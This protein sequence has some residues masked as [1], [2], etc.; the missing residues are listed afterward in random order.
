MKSKEN[1]SDRLKAIMEYLGLCPTVFAKN[2]GISPTAVN[3][4]F[5]QGHIPRKTTIDKIINKY[6]IRREWLENGEGKMWEEDYF[7]ERFLKYGLGARTPKEKVESLM[8]VFECNQSGLAERLGVSRAYIFA[9][10]NEKIKK[11]SYEKIITFTEKE[12]FISK[13]WWR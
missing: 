13:E 9:V 5:T 1:I 2:I 11:I 8:K 6:P 10:I 7:K 3:K 12:K 4:Y